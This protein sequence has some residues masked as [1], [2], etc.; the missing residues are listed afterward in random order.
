L[1]IHGLGHGGR[2]VDV[3]LVCALLA[4]DELDFSWISHGITPFLYL[5]YILEIKTNVKPEKKGV[6]DRET[7]ERPNSRT[8]LEASS[9]FGSAPR[10]I[11][12]RACNG[13]SFALDKKL[14]FQTGT[15]AE[16][17]GRFSCI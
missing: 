12:P 7:S 8:R 5:A 15:G 2:E 14:N 3:V 10:L 16:N 6:S 9:T 17:D 13:R 1:Q 4:G 11:L